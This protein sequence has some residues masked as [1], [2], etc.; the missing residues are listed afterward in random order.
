MAGK[1]QRKRKEPANVSDELWTP[2]NMISMLRMLLVIPLLYLLQEPYSNQIALLALALFAYGTDLLD[3]LVARQFGGESNFGRILDPLADKV[4]I[5]AAMLGMLA[6]GMLPLWFVLAVV[7]RDV[8]IFIAGMYLKRKTGI[9]VQSNYLGK[10]AVVAV[11]LT[12]LA[13]LFS[14]G[15]RGLLLNLMMVL[16]LGLMSASLYMYGER[17]VKMLRKSRK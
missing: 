10:A 15:G 4:F 6:A 7:A 9:L 3:G 8:S 5:I 11:G 1:K 16:S 2:G 14:E 12:F 17:F 13:A